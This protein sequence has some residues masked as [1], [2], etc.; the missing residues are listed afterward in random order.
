M[1]HYITFNSV[2]KIFLEYCF[3]RCNVFH[4]MFIGSVFTIIVR[5]YWGD[6]CLLACCVREGDEWKTAFRS[7]YGSFEFRVMPFGLT[8]A[9][10]SFQ[11]F[12]NTIFGDLLDVYIV[13]Y[14]DDILIF[15]SSLEE[16]RDHVKEVLQQLRH[17][18]LYA[19]AEKCVWEQDSVEFV[20]FHYLTKGL[21][22][23]EDKVLTILDW[24]E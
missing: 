21:C 16:H 3:K 11:R 23:S 9:P 18:G 20:G 10:S 19:K 6:T 4:C 24:P 15:S 5:M 7:R 12:M 14:L 2:I 13:V 8:N 17:H 22:M 1:N